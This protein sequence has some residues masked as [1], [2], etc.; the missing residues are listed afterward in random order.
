MK[1]LQTF[2]FGDV[3]HPAEK[4]PWRVIS[5]PRR[6]AG[7]RGTIK[8]RHTASR[9]AAGSPQHVQ[10]VPRKVLQPSRID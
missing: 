10:K 5:L 3:G 1:I 2:D 4:L 7:G 9:T 6:R 8:E